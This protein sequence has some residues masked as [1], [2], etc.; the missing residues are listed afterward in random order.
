[1][2]AGPSV[3]DLVTH[4]K[5]GDKQ[6]WDALVERYAPLMWS[7]CRRH[8]L[9]SADAEDVAQH[10]WLRLVNQLGSLRD[11]V[12]LP[13]WLATTTQRE[14][15]RVLCAAQG[16]GAVG[17]VVDIETIPDAQA[18][19]VDED[20]LTA[21]RHAALGE[22]FAHLPQDGQRL[23]ALLIADPPVPH[24]EISARLSIPVGSI[25]PSRARYLEKMRRCPA[26]AALISADISAA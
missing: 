8:R 18:R 7:I 2:R 20:L 4:A 11:P 14:C 24:A 3:N 16:P 6:A 13:G 26:I 9:D 21:E 12:A 10:V 22:A 19:A 1:V 15:T 17:Y 23:I 5:K 25:G